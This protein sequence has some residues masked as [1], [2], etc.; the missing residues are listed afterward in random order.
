MQTLPIQLVI[1]ELVEFVHELSDVSWEPF[2][3]VFVW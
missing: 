1:L 3:S 2:A